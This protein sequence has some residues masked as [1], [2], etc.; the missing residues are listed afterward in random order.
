MEGRNLFSGR[1]PSVPVPGKLSI[2]SPE[3]ISFMESIG[4]PKLVISIL[5][6]GLKLPFHRGLPPRYSEPNNASAKLHAGV[7]RKKVAKWLEQGYCHRVPIKPP[8]CSPL[9]VSSKLDLLTGEIK[10]RPCYDAS[11]H[12]NKYLDVPKVKISDLSVSEKLLEPGDYQTC[13]DLENQYFHINIHEA[14]HKY[15]GFNLPNENTGEDEYYCF[16]VMIYGLSMAVHV[17]TRL[18][19]PLMEYLNKRGIRAA[20]MIDDGRVLGRS[21]E[22]AWENHLLALQTF[23]RAGWNIQYAKT[24]TEPTM[25]L[26]HQG[27]T[28]DTELMCYSIPDFKV[29]HLKDQISAVSSTMVLRQFAK[30]VGKL[31]SVQRAIGPVIRI[32]SS[33]QFLAIKVQEQ[34]DNAWDMSFKVPTE[35]F[36]DLQFIKENLEEYNTQPIVNNSTGFCLNSV[37]NVEDLVRPV[38]DGENFGGV[39]ASDP[40]ETQFVSYSVIDPINDIIVDQFTADEQKL[41]SGSRE[42]K[43]VENAIEKAVKEIKPGVKGNNPTILY[44]MTDSQVVCTWLLKG[45]SIESVRKRLVRLYKMLHMLGLRLVPVWLPREHE[46]IV[47]AD[48]VSKF[49]DTDDWGLDKKSFKILEMVSPRKFTLDAFSNCTN[50]QVD[51][52]YSKVISPGTAGVNAFMQNW[53]DDYTYACPPVNMVIDVIRY[54]QA[55]PCCG[56]LVIP[57]WP[58]NMFW[59]VLTIDGAHLQPEFKS[60]RKFRPSL[61]AG[62]F[63]EKSYFMQHK[64]LDMLA[65]YFDSKAELEGDLVTRDRCLLQGCDKC[66]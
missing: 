19:S 23:N 64:K 37:A 25:Q 29:I 47:L 14:H 49:A 36:E 44:W 16:S 42:L 18:T 60:Y 61:R 13:F 27:F 41:S 40:S 31:I 58:K 12:L 52:F 56:V 63:C 34:G 21:K 46:L 26:Y 57:N 45:S 28:T 65:V 43:A 48:S 55:I 7:L 6:D 66:T 33:H 22:E 51:K 59:P 39:W 11:R 62:K 38:L 17:V 35:V 54:I 32:R 1:P 30:I 50:K 2:H 15:L 9:S 8:V 4:A 20:I 24:S 3:S 5:R 53:S 10:L